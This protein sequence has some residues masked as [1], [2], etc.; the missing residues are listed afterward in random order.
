MGQVDRDGMR[1]GGLLDRRD[2]NVPL[3]AK[4]DPMVGTAA[5]PSRAGW[6]PFTL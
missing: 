3:D 4:I 2:P 5:R 6:Q 1:R